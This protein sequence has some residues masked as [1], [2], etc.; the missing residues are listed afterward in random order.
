[1][2]REPSIQRVCRI[3]RPDREAACDR[4]RQRSRLQIAGR[5]QAGD[6][7]A[8]ESRPKFYTKSHG[9]TRK[10]A[11]WLRHLE[12]NAT[13]ASRIQRSTVSGEALPFTLRKQIERAESAGS[14]RGIQGGDL[15]GNYPGNRGGRN[16]ARHHRPDG[17]QAGAVGLAREQF[18]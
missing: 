6:A 7:L 17:V 1:M 11:G 3:A 15:A 14:Q 10:A 5:I 4:R 13:C 2:V 8:W 16:R 12:T 18:A 9:E